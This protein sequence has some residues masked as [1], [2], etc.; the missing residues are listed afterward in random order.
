VIDGGPVTVCRGVAP[1]YKNGPVLWCMSP[2]FFPDRDGFAFATGVESR[3]GMQTTLRYLRNAGLHRI[4]IITATDVAGQEADAALGALIAEPANRALSVVAAEHFGPTDLTVAA[5]LSKMKDARPQ[6]LIAWATGTPL[7]TVLRGVKDAGLKLPVV[8][9]NA[10]QSWQQMEQYTSIVP[11]EYLLYSLRWPSYTHM[12]GGPLKVALAEYFKTMSAAGVHPDGVTAMVWDTAAIAVGGLR[13]FDATVTPEQLRTYFLSLHDVYGAS[14]S[15]DFR[16][17]N[18]RGLGIADTIM[19][20]WN[21]AT[22]LWEAVSGPGGD[23]LR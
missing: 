16:L 4:A 12:R 5:Q 7:A 8:T 20:R 9:S 23:I 1:L 19:A 13:K 11:P 21:P 15:F 10:G 17:G 18:Q 22:K 6:V 3:L 14:G 2:A